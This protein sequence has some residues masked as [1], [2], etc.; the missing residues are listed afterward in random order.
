M[1]CS[2]PPSAAVAAAHGLQARRHH[3]RDGLGGAEHDG[4]AARMTADAT[5]AA[6]ALQRLLPDLDLHG[7]AGL[8][9]QMQFFFLALVQPDEELGILFIMIDRMLTGDISRFMKVFT[10]VFINYGF[11]MYI[12]YPRTGD[13]FQPAVSPEFN[14][15][16]A[17]SRRSI[18]M[19][20]LGENA[21]STHA[22]RT[23]RPSRRGRR[24]SSGFYVVFLY[25]Y[26][27]MALILLLNLLIAMM[28]DTYATVQEQAVRE[29]R[30]GN[31][32]MILRLEMLARAEKRTR[33]V[34]ISYVVGDR[35]TLKE[36]TLR[37]K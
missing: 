9:I 27:I 21:A 29:W 20:L 4:A 2:R 17:R 35:T 18:E 33:S 31:A 32:Q 34:S 36:E 28:G 23:S 14:S 19:A 15:L 13:V 10:I 8:L 26:I 24:S 7:A 12:C 25:Y 1:S 37:S 11:A 30:V 3:R 22:E 6:A 5:E 16:G